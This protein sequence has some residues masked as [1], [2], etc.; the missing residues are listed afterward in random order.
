MAVLG[1]EEEVRNIIPDFGAIARLDARGLIVTAPGKSADFVSRF[2]GPQC[3][4]NEDPVTGSAHTTLIPYW[5]A[6]LGKD[7]LRA[8]QVSSRGGALDCQYLPPRVKIGGEARLY[9]SGEIYI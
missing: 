5:A 7:H 1:T 9:L 4:V 6:K 3:G 2:F 8:L